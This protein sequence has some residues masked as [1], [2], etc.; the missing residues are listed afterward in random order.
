[1]CWA[2]S[3]L[4][5]AVFVYSSVSGSWSHGTSIVFSALGLDV[6]PDGYPVM[7]GWHSYA[8]GCLYWDA[9]TTNKMIKLDINSMESTVVSLPPDHEDEHT[10]FEKM[11]P[12]CKARAEP[13]G[14]R[15]VE[16]STPGPST[17]KPITLWAEYINGPMHRQF[18]SWG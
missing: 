10:I 1:M 18:S 13:R 3:D 5:A 11:E 12:R 17:M 2:K 14:A 16:R 8:Y 6:K 7:C 15:G 4:M 9:I